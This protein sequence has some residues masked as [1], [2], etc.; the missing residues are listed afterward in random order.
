MNYLHLKKGSAL[1]LTNL[2]PPPPGW[3]CFE[4]SLV[5]IVLVVLGKKFKKKCEKFTDSEST[6]TDLRQTKL[7]QNSLLELSD[8]VS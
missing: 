7:N 6:T 5:K 2:N 1:F 8:R 3:E 4:Q